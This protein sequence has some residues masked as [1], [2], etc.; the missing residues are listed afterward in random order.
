M[1][2]IQK[3]KKKQKQKREQSDKK[4]IYIYIYIEREGEK[5]DWRPPMVALLLCI[6]ANN[7]S[8][9]FNPYGL[10]LRRERDGENKGWRKREIHYRESVTVVVFCGGEWREALLWELCL[11]EESKKQRLRERRRHNVF[12]ERE[13]VDIFNK[14]NI[15]Y[16]TN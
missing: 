8:H 7:G 12:L 9:G 6:I 5:K 2:Y 3:E 16:F 1:I 14:N 10:S 11:F 15:F 4:K 13:R